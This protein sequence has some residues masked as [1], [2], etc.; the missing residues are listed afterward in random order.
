MTHD[1]FFPK[2]RQKR[3]DFHKLVRIHEG[4]YIR[5]LELKRRTVEIKNYLSPISRLDTEERKKWRSQ[6]VCK[7]EENVLKIL[8]KT[9][10]QFLP[11][12]KRKTDN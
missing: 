8:R 7:W 1:F 12:D 9:Q 5:I 10:T 2:N 6:N 11:M 4:K 3:K